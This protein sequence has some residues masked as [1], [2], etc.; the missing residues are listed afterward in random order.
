MPRR[1]YVLCDQSKIGR[2]SEKMIRKNWTK[3]QITRIYV[4]KN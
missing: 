2:S 1:R 3:M 4:K